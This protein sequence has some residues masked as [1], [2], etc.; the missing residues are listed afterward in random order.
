MLLILLTVAESKGYS[1]L[2]IAL[3]ATVCL[4]PSLFDKYYG[5]Y[6]CSVKY[7]QQFAH[8]TDTATLCMESTSELDGTVHS[9]SSI[10]M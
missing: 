10:R 2:H 7:I 9:T 4:L 6:C 8:S 5:N 1:I 3:P